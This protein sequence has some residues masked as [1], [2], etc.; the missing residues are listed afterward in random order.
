MR[1]TAEAYMAVLCERMVFS[2]SSKLWNSLG[3]STFREP[4]S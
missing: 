4:A 2:L 3:L 1:G